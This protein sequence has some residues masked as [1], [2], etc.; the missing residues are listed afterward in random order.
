MEDFFE[1]AFRPIARDGADNIEVMLRLQKAFSSIATINNSEIKEI[2][3]RHSKVAYERAEKAF[4]FEQDL[5][6][7]LK[8]CLFKNK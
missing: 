3:K 7:L 6:T 2:A 8:R 5:D 4:K 1:D